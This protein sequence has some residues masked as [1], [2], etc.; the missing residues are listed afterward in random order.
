MVG[1]GLVAELCVLGGGGREAWREGSL[2]THGRLGPTADG[3]LSPA[4]ASRRPRS[5]GLLDALGAK[6]TH[7]MGSPSS[8]QPPGMGRTPPG[9]G[10]G[11]SSSEQQDQGH[12]CPCHVL[13]LVLT[14]NLCRV[15]GT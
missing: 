8:Q 6:T 1:C 5:L 14:P 9:E 13:C 15:P 10:P 12:C 7:L 11:G 3:L 4:A 2:R